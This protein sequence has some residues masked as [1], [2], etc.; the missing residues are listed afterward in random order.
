LH[1]GRDVDVMD[2]VLVQ[3]VMHREPDT[4]VQSM[5]LIE[6]QAHVLHS[7]YNNIAV[8]D[9]Q[10]RLVGVA[11]LH[12]LERAVGVED[13]EKLHV[14]DIMTTSLLRAYP[15][16]TIG[17]ALQRMAARDVGR[18]PVVDRADPTR[19]VGII[20]RGDIAK[21]YQ[22]GMLR[23]DDMADRA[24]QL[25]ISQ[26]E[27]GTEFVELHVKAGSAV[28]DQRVAELQLP[29]ECLLTTRRHNDRMHLLHGN[30]ILEAGDIIL[31]LC[32]P[33]QVN[34]LRKMFEK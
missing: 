10:G 15:D 2:A 34:E 24:N 26:R 13:W 19:L 23:R 28:A 16:E 25:R 29:P 3:E 31:A 4:V 20:R 11:A 6:F 22:R 18:I 14:E 30:D 8:L 7:H 33:S 32:D 27:G 1:L 21:A 17:V 12:D 5:P 9:E